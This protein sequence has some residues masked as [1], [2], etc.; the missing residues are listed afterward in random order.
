MPQELLEKVSLYNKN[1]DL[2]LLSKAY[3]FTNAAHSNQKRISGEPQ[4]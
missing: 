2:S 1:A 3:E 4:Q